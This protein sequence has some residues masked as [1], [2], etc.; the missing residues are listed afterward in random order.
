MIILGVAAAALFLVTQAKAKGTTVARAAKNVTTEILNSGNGWGN[1][2][3]YFSDGTSISPDGKYY[4]GGALI[5][6]PTTKQAENTGGAS[7][8]WDPVSLAKLAEAYGSSSV[9]ADD[10]GVFSSML[11]EPDAWG[12]IAGDLST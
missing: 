9:R 5:W 4:K 7:G 2:W 11:A 8:S 1:G 10:G 12:R 3:R 6:Q